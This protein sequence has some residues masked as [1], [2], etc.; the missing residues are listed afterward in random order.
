MIMMLREE[1]SILHCTIKVARVMLSLQIPL[2][3]P[4]IFLSDIL[5]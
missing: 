3:P 2:N 5:T 1:K 4:I